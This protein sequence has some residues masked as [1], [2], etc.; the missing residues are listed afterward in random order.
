MQSFR[1]EPFLWIHL[2]GLATLPILLQLCWL[3]LAVG[4]PILPVWLEFSIVAAIGVLPVLW[5]QLS[6]PFLIFAVLGVAQ[7]PT[8]LDEQQR[9]V[10]RL[11]RTTSNRL[12]AMIVAVLLVGLL[13][14]LYRTAPIAANVIPLPP[15]WR[16]LGLLVASIAFL[17]SNL[18]LQ[19][20]VSVARVFVTSETEFSKAKPYPVERIARDFTIVGW[21]VNR[22]LPQLTNSQTDTA[23]VTAQVKE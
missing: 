1:S 5:M 13:W 7:K 17:A 8:Q 19:I 14:L 4:D 15:Q 6:R 12:L 21:Q 11:I 20:P 16:G 22:I 3:G 18:F 2:A 10:L 9:K 23:Q